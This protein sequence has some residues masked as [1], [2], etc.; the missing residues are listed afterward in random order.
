MGNSKEKALELVVVTFSFCTLSISLS[1]SL[2]LSRSHVSDQYWETKVLFDLDTSWKYDLPPFLCVGSTHNLHHN[3][4]EGNSIYDIRYRFSFC[5]VF[6]HVLDL[7][8]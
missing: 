6:Y 7:N 5:L 3:H 1:L 4:H 8:I 2:S